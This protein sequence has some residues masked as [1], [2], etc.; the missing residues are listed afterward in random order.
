[1]RPQADAAVCHLLWERYAWDEK[2]QRVVDLV[3]LEEAKAARHNGGATASAKSE[4]KDK[5]DKKG[6]KKDKK[7]KKSEKK[8]KKDK[9]RGDDDSDDEDDDDDLDGDSTG[10]TPLAV[11]LVFSPVWSLYGAAL[12]SDQDFLTRFVEEYRLPVTARDIGATTRDFRVKIQNIFVRWLPVS[13]ALLGMTVRALPSPAAAQRQRMKRLAGQLYQLL[14]TAVKAAKTEPE[15]VTAAAAAVKALDDADSDGLA[16][17]AAGA[18][19]K[20]K[21]AAERARERLALGMFQ[22]D[23]RC[24]HGIISIVKVID[25]QAMGA[26]CGQVPPPK[27][28]VS[29]A[30]AAA[31]AVAGAVGT[32]GAY[33]RGRVTQQSGSRAAAHPGQ[34]QGKSS[35]LF[36]NQDTAVSNGAGA[37]PEGG[38]DDA[39]GQE[40]EEYDQD[41]FVI[42]KKQPQAAGPRFMALARVFAGSFLSSGA[43]A[44]AHKDEHEDDQ[45]GKKMLTVYGPKYA[46]PEDTDPANLSQVRTKY[47]QY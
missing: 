23:R 9:K 40:E 28:A 42:P 26:R 1:V 30:A 21:T 47:C 15:A 4:K 16:D 14:P 19:A 25:L 22:C 18:D 41:G 27:P 8:D 11:A 39:E 31:G 37:G 36:P 13:E 3:R 34:T 6:D 32:R 35:V 43:E 46:G 5:K 2:R 38:D 10:Y 24:P 45:S 17:A 44:G 20:A 7:D 12:A 29:A 33:M